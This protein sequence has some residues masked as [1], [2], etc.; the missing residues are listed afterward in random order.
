MSNMNRMAEFSIKYSDKIK[1]ICSPLYQ[2]FDIKHFWCSKTYENGEFF[3][4]GSNP[5]LHEFYYDSKSYLH[6]PFFR[7]PTLI[8]PGYYFHRDY[9]D[10]SYKVVVDDYIQKFKTEFCVVCLIKNEK[11]LIRFGYASAPNRS[12]QFNN[13]LINNIQLFQK[14][15]EYFLNE[16]K[17]IFVKA[18]DHFVDLKNELGVVY[19]EQLH[20]PQLLNKKEKCAFLGQLGLLESSKV[21]KLSRQEL[22]CMKYLA[23]GFSV[24]QIAHAVEISIR[25]VEHYLES[26]KNKLTCYTKF[27]L[28]QYAN[29][30][31]SSC[32]FFLDD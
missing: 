22:H 4:I 21:E 31:Q 3:C 13:T 17:N 29:L 25:T 5:S 28:F 26:I 27:E 18:N 1:K 30:L 32:G 23:Q 20:F 14:F 16:T 24:S 19:D 7:K 15:N 2:N 8:Q 10:N 6:N 11:E 9:E 12:R